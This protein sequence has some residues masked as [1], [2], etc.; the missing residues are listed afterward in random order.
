MS[1]IKNILANSAAELF[2]PL[3]KKRIPIEQHP[4]LTLCNLIQN[5]EFSK[6]SLTLNATP[7]LLRD[8]IFF[9]VWSQATDVCKNGE[10]WGEL[11]ALTNPQR[12]LNAIKTV[13]EKK[14]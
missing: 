14:T 4:L 1:I 13:V 7:K 8:R 10:K 11:N 2:L 6:L 9:E 12:L 5:S 3:E